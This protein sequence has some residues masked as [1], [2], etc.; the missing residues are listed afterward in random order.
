MKTIFSIAGLQFRLMLRSKATLAVMFGLPLVLTL[1]FG[2]M[3]Q[4]GPAAYPVAVVD[5]DG[6]AATGQVIAALAADPSLRVRRAA[7]D[8]VSGLMANYKA[9]AAVVL[10]AGF[11][12]AL[13]A[14]AG[15]EVQLIMPP[16]GNLQVAIRPALERAVTAVAGEYALAARLAGPG[17][18]AA[19]LEAA[20]ATIAAGREQIG[21][22]TAVHAVETVAA[23]P[24]LSNVSERALG[25][26]VMFVMLVVFS[27]SGVILEE[28][29]NGTWGRLL[30]TPAARAQV[31]AGYVLSFLITGL[32]Q[33]AVLVTA[34]TLLFGVTWGPLLPLAAVAAALILCA[35]GLGL[36]L[37]GLVRT[38][39]QQRTVGSIVIIATSMLG[40]VYWPLEFVS[41][42]MRRIGYLTPQAW[43]MDGFR[44]V[45]LRGG[46]WAHLVWPLTVH[47][48]LAAIFMTAGLS[49]VRFE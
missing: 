22:T 3:G 38:A 37:A 33:F 43:A 9:V 10:P 31:V 25:F 35:A 49:R 7:A 36:F 29:Q 8:E 23:A 18:G 5:Q 2:G 42:T 24:R 20:F 21:V 27:M 34:S 39:E 19:D 13:D 14:G 6:T 41:A 45:V 47:V 26:T 44:E 28:R 40:G 11:Q 32:F 30:A 16:A 46:A 15:P 4:G 17:A 48:A 12:Q 1:I